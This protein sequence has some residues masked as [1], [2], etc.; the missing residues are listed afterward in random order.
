MLKR[1]LVLAVLAAAGA[2]AYAQVSD[3]PRTAEGRPDFHG[4]WESRWLTPFERLD[5]TAEATVTGEAAEA[6]AAL[7]MKGLQSEGVAL[8]PR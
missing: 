5:G 8:P 2:H 6:Y 1:M 4:V 3:I 7:R